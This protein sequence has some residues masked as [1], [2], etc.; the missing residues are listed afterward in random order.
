MSGDHDAGAAFL[1]EPSHGPQPCLQA[2]VIGL[3]AVDGVPLGAVPGRLEQAVQHRQVGQGSIGDD[4]DRSDLGRPDGPFEEAAGGGCVPSCGHEH[5][6]DLAELVDRSIDV[7]PAAGDL[8]V[9]LIGSPAVADRMPAGPGGLGQ[10]RDEAR[11][12]QR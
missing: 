1:F 8:D 12:T 5:I 4:L 10:Q 7:T 2:A 11:W 9:G 6:D 3:N